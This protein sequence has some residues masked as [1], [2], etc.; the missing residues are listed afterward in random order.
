MK[1]FGLGIILLL[2]LT[3]CSQV[4]RK[5]DKFYWDPI[6]GLFRITYGAVK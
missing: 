4:E 1:R 3:S 6:K 2:W 5:I